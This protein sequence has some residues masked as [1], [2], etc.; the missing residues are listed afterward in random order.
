MEPPP[1][2][3][4]ED[5]A[6]FMRIHAEGGELSGDIISKRVCHYST[7]SGLSIEGRMSGRSGSGVVWDY[8]MGK[9]R[10]LAKLDLNFDKA[11]G[12]VD[13]R[14]VDQAPGLFPESFRLRKAASFVVEENE[15]EVGTR[16]AASAAEAMKET[17]EMEAARYRGV[18]CKSFLEEVNKFLKQSQIKPSKSVRKGVQN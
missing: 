17:R 7:Y 5:D 1:W 13:V 3:T 16:Y 10:A 15:D 8:F 4:S 9:R 2:T 6:V 11:K 14:V 18:I 12:L